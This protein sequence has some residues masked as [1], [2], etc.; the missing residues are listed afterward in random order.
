MKYAANVNGH[1]FELELQLNGKPPVAICEGQNYALDIEKIASGHIL[2]RLN[3]RVFEILLNGDDLESA[4]V[5]GKL[6]EVQLRDA[7]L[8]QLAAISG[9][10]IKGGGA[11]DIK[12][13]MPSPTASSGDIPEYPFLTLIYAVKPP[14]R[15]PP[16]SA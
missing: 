15:A 12:A 7:R 5:N 11:E 4:H 3:N 9:T 16:S 10:S 13:P 2:V 1:E 8:Q 6:C 14:A